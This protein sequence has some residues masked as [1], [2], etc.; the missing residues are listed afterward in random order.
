MTRSPLCLSLPSCLLINLAPPML[1]RRPLTAVVPHSSQVDQKL[2]QEDADNAKSLKFVLLSPV[3]AYQL[4]VVP[5]SCFV[6]PHHHTSYR[7]EA[8]TPVKA[9]VGCSQDALFMH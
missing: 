7:T 8:A 2:K 5:S 6:P 1:L 3:V 9:T 4:C